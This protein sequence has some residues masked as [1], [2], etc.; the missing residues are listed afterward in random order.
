MSTSF[1]GFFRDYLTIGFASLLRR[2][3][4]LHLHG[5]GFEEFYRRQ[6][7]IVRHLIRSNLARTDKIIVLGDLLKEQFCVVGKFVEDKLIVVPNGFPR[8]LP[9]PKRIARK[10]ACRFELLYLSSLMPSKGYLDVL[11]AVS[12]LNNLFPNKFH[13]NLC[14]G[15]ISASTE[16]GIAVKNAEELKGYIENRGL[17][18][19][20][21]YHGQ[22]IGNEKE[23]L[24]ITA[25]IFLLPTYYPWE[26][27]P[28][29][30]IE[31]LAFS[32][33]VIT[34]RHKGIPELVEDGINGLFVNAGSPAEIRR[35]VLE[36][37]SD[38]ERYFRFCSASR[39]RYERFFRR[40][41]HL[42]RL[43]PVVR[44]FSKDA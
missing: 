28:L 9:E 42:S 24:F 12:M 20:V 23:E 1:F 26:G 14:G 44:G 41:V 11:D 27:Q 39:E 40:D 25:D 13:L 43:I 16:V 36:I 30:I 37:T 10:L 32:L 5:G 18:D 4:I 2:R 15:F 6:N 8:D 21:T 35:A 17:E 29:S 22:V 7:A 38:D 19:I 33:P 34:C 31:A 3:T